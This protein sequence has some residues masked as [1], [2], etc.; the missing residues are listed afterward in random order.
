[1]FTYKTHPVQTD[2]AREL[3]AS[4]FQD[5]FQA[6]SPQTT[7]GQYRD[8]NPG[9]GT[10]VNHRMQRKTRFGEKSSVGY[11][12]YS[13][14]DGPSGLK[15][16]PPRW[17][18]VPSSKSIIPNPSRRSRARPRPRTRRS[19]PRIANPTRASSFS[20]NQEPK[21]GKHLIVT[22]FQIKRV[23]EIVSGKL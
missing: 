17:V 4:S 20:S 2:P 16:A 23:I 3:K 14:G 8:H 21:A 6:S 5:G 18:N 22:I 10:D 9:S 11:M 13:R 19:Q 7:T 15:T 1:M 12:L